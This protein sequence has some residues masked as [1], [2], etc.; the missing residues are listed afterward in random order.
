MI[1]NLEPQLRQ[2]PK[3]MTETFQKWLNSSHSE[4]NRRE[5]N[6]SELPWY[7]YWKPAE[8]NTQAD[9]SFSQVHVAPLD[10]STKLACFY[11]KGECHLIRDYQ[12]RT[13]DLQVSKAPLNR[14]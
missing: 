9:M 14:N 11:C 1:L 7:S 4:A 8:V 13:N 10:R 12:K 2:N 5:R 6:S 3:S